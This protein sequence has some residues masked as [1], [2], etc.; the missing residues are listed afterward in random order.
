MDRIYTYR[1]Y[2]SFYFAGAWSDDPR[3]YRW[4]VKN[5]NRAMADRF[6]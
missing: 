1:L 3:L 2:Y 4:Y 5:L 6:S